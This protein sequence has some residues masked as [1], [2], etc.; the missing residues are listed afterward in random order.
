MCTCVNAHRASHTAHSFP[1]WRRG[2]QSLEGLGVCG[3]CAGGFCSCAEKQEPAQ[4]A[5]SVVLG[6]GDG[7]L[8][9]GEAGCVLPAVAPDVPVLAATWPTA[10]TGRWPHELQWVA[11]QRVPRWR[12]RVMRRRGRPSDEDFNE[13]EEED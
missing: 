11:V 1:P 12:P 3:W 7:E 10:R 2:G 6:Q 4:A 13:N 9:L 5:R 8:S